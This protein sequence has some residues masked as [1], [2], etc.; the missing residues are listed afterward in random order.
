M[1]NGKLRAN[2]MSAG[3]VSPGSRNPEYHRRS[4]PI[5]VRSGLAFPRDVPPGTREPR[6][7]Y[8][9][10]VREVGRLTWVD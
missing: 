5:R 6:R 9:W 2:P 7:D 4:S 1:A 8:G 10:T 3:L